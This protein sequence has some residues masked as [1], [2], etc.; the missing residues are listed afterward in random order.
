MCCL[1]VV[2]CCNTKKL[3]YSH[4]GTVH[5]KQKK[6]R[7]KA[8]LYRDCCCWNRL[9]CDLFVSMFLA[10]VNDLFACL[11]SVNS[12]VEGKYRKCVE[13][14][15]IHS[16]C[17]E[18]NPFD[19]L[20][21]AEELEVCISSVTNTFSF[22]VPAVFASSHALHFNVL[23]LSPCF[24]SLVPS[25]W[26]FYPWGDRLLE[27]KAIFKNVK[28][29]FGL[30]K[31]SSQPLLWAVQ[32]RTVG[33]PLILCISVTIYQPMSLF[34]SSS[35]QELPDVKTSCINNE[36]CITLAL[37]LINLEDN[38]KKWKFHKYLMVRDLAWLKVIL[39]NLVIIIFHW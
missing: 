37:N 9:T 16:I 22:V 31:V 13:S 38:E 26:G 27:E 35:C 1:Y 29:K 10:L 3:I 4:L 23:C 15:V 28:T 20:G 25:S 32:H 12:V 30:L 19:K 36:P 39:S 6:K 11:W 34:C 2:D 33:V 21:V 7:G 24:N 8:L 17:T 5:L 14:L 18:H